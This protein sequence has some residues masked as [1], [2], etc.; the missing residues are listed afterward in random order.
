MHL[1]VHDSFY[2]G[3]PALRA[4]FDERHA[5]RL[6]LLADVSQVTKPLAAHQ[7]C[8]KGCW[9]QSVVQGTIPS[10]IQCCSAAGSKTRCRHARTASAG[11]S[12]TSRTSA[13]L[14]TC[15]QAASGSREPVFLPCKTIQHPGRQL[16]W[17]QQPPLLPRY[18]LLRTPADAFFPREQYAALQDALLDFGERRLGCRGMSPAWVACYVDGCRQARPARVARPYK[19]SCFSLLPGHTCAPGAC[20]ASLQHA[21]VGD[22]YLRRVLPRAFHTQRQTLWLWR[23][24]I[25]SLRFRNTSH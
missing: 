18:T 16:Q 14:C 12:G 7:A 20:L 19:P 5:P 4:H 21:A 11:T 2:A 25:N 1:R 17:V 8:S 24:P 9:Q 23:A 3:A 15:S 13:P 10:V 6:G 22:Q